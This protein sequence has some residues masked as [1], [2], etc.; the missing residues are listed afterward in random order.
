[1]PLGIDYSAA[2]LLY[3]M[4]VLAVVGLHT[5]WICT[6]NACRDHSAALPVG[7]AVAAAG[8]AALFATSW[9]Q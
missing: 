3:S 4:C 5:N 2:G 7:T 6:L 1:M 8:A 9:V